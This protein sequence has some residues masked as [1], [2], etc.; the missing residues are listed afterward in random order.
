VKYGTPSSFGF[1]TFSIGHWIF[2][3]QY[4]Y[5]DIQVIKTGLDEIRDL[6]VQFLHEGN[7]QFTYDKCHL[8][9]WSDDYVF[10]LNGSKIGYGAVWGLNDQGTRDA[11]FEFYILPPFRKLVNVFFEAF[12]TACGAHTIECQ[13][14]DR[15][16]CNMLYEY[17]R[18]IY[19]EAI[20]FEDHYTSSLYMPEVRF[21]RKEPDTDTG[22]DRGGYC[23]VLN[24]EEVAS[25]GFM[26]NY[27]MPYADIYME[28][29]EQH[30]QKGYGSLLVQELKKEIY[31]IGRVPAA[32]CNVNN[33]ASKSTLLKAGFAECGFRLCGEVR[34]Q[35]G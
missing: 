18:D 28:V 23:L 2:D 6:R 8:Y 22:Y 1:I 26:L 15:L 13:S 3:I 29:K 16:L 20:L 24:E 30:R 34:I 14:N 9:G 25:G 32:R 10:L 19:A 5:M 35:K 4:F 7:I 12:C 31:L 17:A 33:R 27:N 21:G 11:I